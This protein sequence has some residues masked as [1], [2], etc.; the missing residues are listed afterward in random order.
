MKK[1]ALITI[2]C[3]LLVPMAGFADEAAD[4][5]RHLRE[6]AGAE[7]HQKDEAD[8]NHLLRTNAEHEINITR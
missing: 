1:S 7:D 3:L 2:V 5:A 6:R 8:D 4:V